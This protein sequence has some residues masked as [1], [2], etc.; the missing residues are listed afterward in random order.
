ML[1]IC[2]LGNASS[3]VAAN[4][5]EA[6]RGH[7]EALSKQ[8]SD[9]PFGLPL[10][11]ESTEATDALKGD[12]YAVVDYPFKTVNSSLNDPVRG[13][14]NWCDM[15]ILHVNIKH[16]QVSNDRSGTKLIVSIGRKFEQTPEE[17]Y[18][19]EFNYRVAAAKPDYLKIDL[20]AEKGPM[21]TKNYRILLE[22]VAIEAGRTFLHFTYSYGY[23]MAAHLAVNTYL[24]TIGRDKVGFNVTGRQADGQPE[25]I[26]GVRGIVERNTMRYYLSID[27]YLSALN[28]PDD[29]RLDKRLDKWFSA[30]ERYARQL[31]EVERQDYMDMK[32][33]EYQRMHALPKA[34]SGMTDPKRPN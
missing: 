24:A 33:N 28:L 13:P 30:T 1:L 18:P 22:A 25:Y 6:L 29:Q 32:H 31:H 10:Y 7:Y 11:L 4:D 2:T 15:L 27:A 3:T 8:L 16:C 12:I 20:T 9:N 5:A 34:S 26:N 19:V 23:G 17:A 21:G 14:A